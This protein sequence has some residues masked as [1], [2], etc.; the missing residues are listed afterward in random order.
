MRIRDRFMACETNA[1]VVSKSKNEDDTSCS[2]Q[3]WRKTHEPLARPGQ[4]IGRIA[5]APFCWKLVVTLLGPQGWLDA[6]DPTVCCMTL[7][8]AYAASVVE[9]HLSTQAL[10]MTIDPQPP[11]AGTTSC[12][13]LAV[14]R[15][16]E[17]PK[18]IT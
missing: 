9:R 16:V 3:P 11:S 12:P 17:A 13:V 4:T 6:L 1:S 2:L 8:P 15:P 7:W 10:L 5:L 18:L 14:H